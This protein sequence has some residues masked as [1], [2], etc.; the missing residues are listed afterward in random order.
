MGVRKTESRLPENFQASDLG[1]AIV[2]AD[3]RCS[4]VSFISAPLVV[5]RE[6]VYV[7]FVTDTALASSVKS[8]EWS[9]AEDAGTPVIKTTDFGQTSYIPSNEGK[10]LLK[11]RMLDVGSSEVAS[12]LLTQQIGPLNATLEAMIADAA[13]KPGPSMGNADAMREL[14]NDHNPYYINARLKAP[15]AGDRF[16][17]FLFNMVYVSALQR[18]PDKRHNQLEQVADSLNTGTTEFVAATAPGLGVA[19]VRLPLIAMMLPPTI[20]PFTELPRSDVENALADEQ[21]RQKLAVLSE[22]ERIDLFNL[23]RFPKSNIMLCGK[24]LEA[25]RDKYFNGVSFDAVLTKMSGIMSDWII[26]NYNKGP[27]HRG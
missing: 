22:T 15:E 17:K 19:G 8:F 5:A 14:I 25:L 3:G 1:E 27:L 4:I 18:R 11:V 20:I 9:F 12:L 6:N 2:A 13:N 7:V 24:L 10:L 16:K 26:L 23:V 21:L